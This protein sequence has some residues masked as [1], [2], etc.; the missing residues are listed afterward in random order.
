LS[1]TDLLGL[2]ENFYKGSILEFLFNVICK[3]ILGHLRG[4]WDLIGK[5]RRRY[6]G[7]GE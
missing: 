6:G 2:R 4:E 3:K 1:F 7:R 5:E